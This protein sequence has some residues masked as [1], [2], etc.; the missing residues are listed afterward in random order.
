[1]SKSYKTPGVYIE[2]VST[3]PLS[4]N[5]VP[6]S[7][8]AFIGYT[9][10]AERNG[11]SLHRIPTRIGSLNEFMDFFGEEFYPCF[12]LKSHQV[13]SSGPS[14]Q[15]RATARGKG[16]LAVR[17][18][19]DRHIEYLPDN[20][21]YLFYGLKLFYANGGGTCYIVSVG[22]Y[23][24]KTSTKISKDE[25]LGGLKAISRVNET[26]M[27]VIPDA[28]GLGSSKDC[29]ALYRAM[30]DQCESLND[31]IAILDIYNGFLPRSTGNL[32]DEI[33]TEFRDQIG[34][35]SLKYGTAYYPWLESDVVEE[36]SL[37]YDN[38]DDDFDLKSMLP[39]MEAVQLLDHFP[40]DRAE[41]KSLLLNEQPELADDLDR[42]ESA[43]VAYIKAAK[44]KLHAALKAVSP[45]YAL[46][47]DKLRRLENLNPPSCAMAGIYARVDESRGVWKVPANESINSIIKPSVTISQEEQED[48]N[49][50]ARTGKSI[51]AIR[52]FIGK[53]TL[54]WG[55]RTLAGNDQEWRYVNVRRFF[56]MVEESIKNATEPFVF[57]P[58]DAHTWKKVKTMIE[59][60]LH[61]QWRAG[62]LAGAK[63]AD[64]FFVNIGLG[65]TMTRTDITE[66]RM[67]VQIGMAVVRPAEFIIFRF[68]H[69]MSES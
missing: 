39:E 44:S 46:L 15:I 21:F 5:E 43:L 37:T 60:F 34:L 35:E 27:L 59:S 51:N 64:A 17:L 66:G 9:Q 26:S 8:P 41:F 63:P 11:K 2:E 61:Q 24:E 1:M 12:S 4:V 13:H 54:V 49:V 36:D 48:L 57:E 40:K 65:E 29:Y 20:V 3:T 47:I 53:G 31:R 50:D 32:T 14:N 22:T 69:K 56:N 67:I 23:G 33:I 19:E 52:S 18:D 7:I 28:V 58:N 16:S 42:L 45:S 25:L 62:A 30:L 38:I 6:T 55:A 68:Q 10:K